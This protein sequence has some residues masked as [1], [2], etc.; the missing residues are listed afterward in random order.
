MNTLAE[1]SGW[2][3]PPMPQ[4]DRRRAML[5]IFLVSMAG[6]LLE[7]AY[8]RIISYKLWYYYTYFVVGLALLGIGSGGV[9]LAVSTRLRAATTE[10]IVRVSCLAAACIVP[11]GYLVIARMPIDTVRIWDYGTLSS[12]KNVALLGVISF[13]LFVTFLCVGIVVSTIL[14]RSGDDISRVYF[15]DLVGAALGCLVAIPVI[16]TLSPPAVVMLS[17][18]VFALAALSTADSLRTPASALGSAL[19]VV[20]AVVIAAHSSIPDIQPEHGK[21]GAKYALYSEWG[22]VFRVDVHKMTDDNYLLA[23]DATFGS[24]IW[25]YN[26]DPASQTRF[27][28][29]TRHL[30]FDVLGTPPAKTLIVGSAGGNEILAAL[31]FKAPR[32]EGVELNPVTVGILRHKFAKFTGNL[33]TQPGVT[34]HQD[35]ARSF[36]ARS[37]DHYD[38]VWFVAPDSYAANNAVSSGAFVLSES[39]L[40][41]VEMIE[42]SLQHLS[43]DGIMVTQF[44]ELDFANRPNRT[45]RYVMTARA[46]LRGIGVQDPS[47]HIVVV[48]ESGTA[49]SLPTVMIKRT[50]FTPD[51]VQRLVA[52]IPTKPVVNTGGTQTVTE[53]WRLIHAPGQPVADHIVGRLAA[54]SNADEGN[55]AAT[56]PLRIDAVR[57]NKPFFWHFAGFGTVLRNLGHPITNQFDPE[58]SIG[59][60]V[61][62]LLLGFAIVYALVFLLLP[63]AFVR[64][65]WSALPAKGTSAVYFAALGLGFMLFEITM[66]QRLAR[67][68]GYPTYSLTVT[69]AALLVSTG[70]GALISHRVTARGRRAM[71]GVFAVLCALTLVYEFALDGITDSVIDQSLA[72]RVVVALVALFPLGLCLG[73]FM[74]LGLAQV[75]RL[76]PGEQYAAWAWAVNG[77]LSVVGSVL[78]TILAMEFG[79]KQVQWLALVLYG[80]AVVAYLALA[81]KPSAA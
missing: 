20:L 54:A 30:P 78:T 13:V 67:L 17:A 15:G 76:A 41:T 34:I 21:L 35:D 40:Y 62:L 64:K 55:V 60:R 53:N 66:I 28:I 14:G 42:R 22:P 16:V 69:L 68:L 1:P 2:H 51:E 38:L 37:K 52:A 6:L 80:A 19:V 48:D 5:A 25:R 77:F 49:A 9:A 57:D 8:T 71:G 12:F 65:S 75:Q 7:V 27:D 63:F 47:K 39:Y 43:D 72:V 23:H 56:Y 79:F 32:I 61:L 44:G 59:E 70:L 10:R 24:G 45:A 31:H 50:P 58:N 4:T 11:I 26:G 74:P 73:L 81:R 29:D 18:L 36:V 3:N 46:A 33:A